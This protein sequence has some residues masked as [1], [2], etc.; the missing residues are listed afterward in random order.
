MIWMSTCSMMRRGGM[1][2][3]NLG[4]GVVFPL[5]AGTYFLAFNPAVDSSEEKTLSSR[6]VD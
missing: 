5:K 2:D 3:F 6:I 1:L 4:K